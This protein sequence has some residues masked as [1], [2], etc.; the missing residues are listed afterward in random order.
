M[1]L[2]DILAGAI[3]YCLSAESNLAVLAVCSQKPVSA[4]WQEVAFQEHKLAKL[5][6]DFAARGPVNLLD[7]H[8][9]YAPYPVITGR[10]KTGEEALAQL[11][12][13]N[14]EL[15]DSLD[16]LAASLV[17]A[18]LAEAMDELCRKVRSAARRISM[19]STTLCDA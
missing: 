7:T 16:V 2:R 1:P 18:E 10:P 17:P 14:H 19:I 6:A 9:Q 4:A 15:T 12:N 8:F 13:F 11:V 5:I 3:K